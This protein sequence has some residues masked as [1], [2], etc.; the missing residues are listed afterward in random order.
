MQTGLKRVTCWYTTPTNVV[1]MAAVIWKGKIYYFTWKCCQNRPR[2][3]KT[4]TSNTN[5]QR[6]ALTDYGNTE[7]SVYT[8][9]L[10]WDDVPFK[11]F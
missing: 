3:F 4:I 10:L 11:E 2:D 8:E 1:T 6:D 5:H 9:A 7:R